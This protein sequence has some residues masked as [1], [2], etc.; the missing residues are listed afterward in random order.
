MARSI[1]YAVWIKHAA[2]FIAAIALVWLAGALP[3]MINAQP[4]LTGAPPPSAGAL[5]NGLIAS[6]PIFIALAICQALTFQ[7]VKRFATPVFLLGVFIL[8]SLM[9]WRYAGMA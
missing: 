3:G 2:V 7:Y 5:V 6:W 8:A 1:P 4:E 9:A